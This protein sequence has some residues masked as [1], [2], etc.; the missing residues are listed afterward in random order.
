[1]HWESVVHLSLLHGHAFM[2]GGLLPMVVVWMLYV[3]HQLSGNA[4]SPKTLGWTSGLYLPATS[5]AILLILYKGY[6]YL[7]FVRF[8]QRDFAH[9]AESFFFGSEVARAIVYGV[10]HTALFV[11]LSALLIAI[12]KTLGKPKSPVSNP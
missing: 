6:H 2:M 3:A 9:I 1:M 7:L 10:T 5:I 11:S 4:V 8:G 12:W